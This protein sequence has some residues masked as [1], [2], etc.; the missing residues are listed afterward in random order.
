MCVSVCEWV[1]HIEKCF[2]QRCYINAVHIPD[3]SIAAKRRR[4]MTV[5]VPILLQFAWK[6]LVRAGCDTFATVKGTVK[7]NVWIS[8][9]QISDVL[10]ESEWGSVCCDGAGGGAG[11]H[12]LS[13]Q[14]FC[15][16]LNLINWHHKSEPLLLKVSAVVA[17]RT[18]WRS[19]IL[20]W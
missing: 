4:V 7:A 5:C 13:W 12:V 20:H 10:T 16:S 17:S 14:M 6:S 9:G 18:H 19:W 11:G 15:P 3:L 1:R 8:A 2:G